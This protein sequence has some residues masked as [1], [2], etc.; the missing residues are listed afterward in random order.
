MM[1]C[2]QTSERFS[3]SNRIPIG[4]FYDNRGYPKIKTPPMIMVTGSPTPNYM[5]SAL[6]KTDSDENGK[7]PRYPFLNRKPLGATR[8]V[9]FDEQVK[10]KARTP[11]PNKTWYEKES[12]TMPMKLYPNDYDDAD[13]YSNDDGDIPSDSEQD[14]NDQM[15]ADPHIPRLGTPTPLLRKIQQN[16]LW[17][18]PNAVGNIYSTGNLLR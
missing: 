10:V 8:S 17:P 11:S 1:G 6:K 15:Y 4:R 2:A 13:D 12:S 3:S 14:Y 5:K 7:N 18:K 16:N 9:N